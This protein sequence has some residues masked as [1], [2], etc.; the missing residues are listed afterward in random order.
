MDVFCMP[1]A[2]CAG[3]LNSFRYRIFVPLK[4]QGERPES[5]SLSAPALGCLSAL[6]WRT[7]LQQA[8][9][10]VQLSGIPAV[11]VLGC[12]PLPA[13]CRMLQHLW[14]KGWHSCSGSILGKFFFLIP[15][16]SFLFCFVS[17]FVVVVQFTHSRT[18]MLDHPSPPTAVRSL[19]KETVRANKK[20]TMYEEKFQSVFRGTCYFKGLSEVPLELITVVSEIRQ[21][22]SCSVGSQGMEKMD[23]EKNKK[24]TRSAV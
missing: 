1:P 5:L 17:V 15:P 4:S 20:Q 3:I 10:F 11:S 7:Y 6:P 21:G 13:A 23:K 16:V 8:I 12:L 22:G 14:P 24:P 18:V 2:W 19:Y 9:S